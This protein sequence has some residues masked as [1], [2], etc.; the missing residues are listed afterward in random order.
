MK[1]LLLA[2]AALAALAGP[3]YATDQPPSNPLIAALADAPASLAQQAPTF[4]CYDPT[5]K[6]TC[7]HLRT[8]TTA[9]G[10][11]TT[12]DFA[13]GAPAWSE[14]AVSKAA[15]DY[16]AAVEKLRIDREQVRKELE[17]APA[18]APAATASAADAQPKSSPH[19]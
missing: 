19:Y 16:Q 13:D 15:A 9:R 17:K 2:G 11:Y 5:D 4:D 18:A 1:K 6:N 7:Q 10:D 14:E 3:A 8:I 12:V